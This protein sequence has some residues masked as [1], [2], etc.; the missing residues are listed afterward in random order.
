MTGPVVVVTGV[1][2]AGKT[3]PEARAGILACNGTEAL[4]VGQNLY[5]IP[6]GLLLS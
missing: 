4:A 6:I 2:Q 5:A 3:T 1:R